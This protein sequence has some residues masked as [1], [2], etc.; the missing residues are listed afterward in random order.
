MNRLGAVQRRLFYATIV[1]LLASGACWALIHYLGLRPYLSEPLLMKV[2]GAAA[3][4]AL[5]LIGGLLPA[6][7]ASGWAL[8]QNRSSGALMLAAC[9]LLTVTGYFLYYLGG[10]TAREASSYVHLA[11]GLALPF[12]LGAHLVANPSRQPAALSPPASPYPTTRSW[13]D[14]KHRC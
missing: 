12:A 1:V 14:G 2:H 4:A 13:P 7:V 6:H 3:M 8:R 11:L 5:I 10:E 9:G